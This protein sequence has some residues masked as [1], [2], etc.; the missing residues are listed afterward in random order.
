MEGGDGDKDLNIFGGVEKSLGKR[1]SAFLEYD[2]AFNDNHASA[3]GL[4]R[5]YL[6]LSIQWSLGS[7]LVLGFNVKDMLE[8]QKGT[9]SLDRSLRLD[10]V[11]VF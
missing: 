7:G 6:N 9:T 2:F 10:Y 5:G 4:N 1:V 8:N 11:G 3:L